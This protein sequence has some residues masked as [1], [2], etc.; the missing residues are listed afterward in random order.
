MDNERVIGIEEPAQEARMGRNESEKLDRM[1]Q[2]SSLK[3][4]QARAIELALHVISTPGVNLR[5]EDVMLLQDAS[6]INDNLH[7]CAVAA[8]KNA[9]M[10]CGFFTENHSASAPRR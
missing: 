3:S 7:F 4:H 6:G 1:T 9:I 5:M 8:L 10:R 2:E